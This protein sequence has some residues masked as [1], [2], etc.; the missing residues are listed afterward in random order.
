MRHEIIDQAQQPDSKFDLE[1]VRRNI[2]LTPFGPATL[3]SVACGRQVT[4]ADL[5]D[6]FK[7][8][9][10]DDAEMIQKAEELLEATGITER[11]ASWEITTTPEEIIERT[12]QIGAD[13]VTSLLQQKGWGNV[14][15]LIDTSASLTPQIGRLVM[16]KAGLDPQKTASRSYRMACAGAIA[17]VVDSLADPNLKGKR[18]IVCALEPVS[19]HVSLDQC[20]K[21]SLSLPAIFGDDFAAIAFNTS[22]FDIISP[23]THIV[24][25]GAP[26]RFHV[27][28]PLPSTREN[29]VPAHYTFGDQGREIS[30]IT[31]EGY[32]LQIQTPEN[33]MPSSMDG[34]KTFKFF[35]PETI[36]VIRDVVERAW[37]QG[38]IVEQALMHQPSK[39][40]NEGFQR[41]AKE[42]ES[43]VNLR[44]PDFLL[45]EIRRSNSSSGTSL[46]IWQH[47][48]KV[49]RLDPNKPLLV[50]APG[51]G[52][53]ISAGVIVPA[54]AA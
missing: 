9:S 37:E 23:R 6:A 42:I 32:F 33:G 5:I 41:K 7:Q 34:W 31:P 51:I 8:Q 29:F 17:G 40:V 2:E 26:I 21:E 1:E 49:G 48:A 14:D 52:S 27:D 16:E 54:K 15:L 22:D 44:I 19:Q 45:G 10:G 24:F 43:L 36:K 38:I 46:V 30:S 20:T 13:I 39:K 25:D 50:C 53:A 3:A 28:Y 47:L 35:V 11:R 18:V 12:S 4:N